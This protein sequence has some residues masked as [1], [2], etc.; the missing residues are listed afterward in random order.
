MSD[1][2]S[3]DIYIP[4]N[5]KPLSE[6]G[7]SQIRIGIQGP[8]FGGKT[9]ASL[10]FPNPIVL[11]FD[12]KVSAHTHR[13]DVIIVP[14]HD[15]AFVERYA[16]RAGLQAPVNRKDALPIWLNTEGVKLKSNQTLIVDGSTGIEENFH[17][18]YNFH[19]DDLATTK[20]GNIDGLV[21]WDMAKSY[22]E[23]IHT[24]LKSVPANVIYICH[25]V[26]AVDKEG[27][28]NGK[29]RPLLSGQPGRK[30][31]GNLTDLFRAITIPKPLD[32][33]Q[34][35]KLK[36]WA[37]IDNIVLEEWIKSTPDDHQTIYLWQTCAD[38]VCE[39]G[40]SSLTGVPKYVI[41]SYKTFEKYRKNKTT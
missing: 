21:R 8:P 39:C 34:R 13:K 27:K 24:C 22:F 19:E 29:V 6:I 10:T 32:D 38:D 25:E 31:G 35:D 30:L 15:V 4:P 3:Q 12:R 18:W 11:S 37:K 28:P 41:A 7:D 40:T 20:S 17:I 9:T 16:K 36:K 14:F 1:T 26:D 5:C 33:T 23:E 2:L